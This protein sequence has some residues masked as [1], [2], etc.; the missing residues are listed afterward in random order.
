V[1]GR[2]HVTVD[3][4]TARVHSG[5]R[6]RGVAAARIALRLVRDGAES[7]PETLVRLA[8]VRGGLPEPV[9]NETVLD[10]SGRFI[11]RA[12]MQYPAFSVVVEYDGEQHRLD[13]SQYARDERR[14]EDF[15][16]AGHLV[17]RIRKSGLAALHLEVARVERALVTR[18]WGR[19]VR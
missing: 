8:I 10:G 18:G 12:D 19:N 13:D 6:R 14:L 3:E 17:V 15:Q 4:L 7:R 16:L 5:F 1:A 2:P 11:G 9:L